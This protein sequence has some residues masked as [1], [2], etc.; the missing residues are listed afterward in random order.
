ML[1]QTQKDFVLKELNLRGVI[2]RNKCLKNYITRLG[3][4]INNLKNEG[5]EFKTGYQDTNY[6]R[7]YY[8]KLIENRKQS[9]F[10]LQ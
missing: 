3:A 6:G 8:Y 4:I 5:Y 1:N 10:D 7:D 9:K 2:T